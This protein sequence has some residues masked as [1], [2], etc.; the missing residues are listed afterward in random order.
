M[1]PYITADALGDEFD[2]E[3]GK[4]DESPSVSEDQ[5]IA[6]LSGL[7]KRRMKAA[8]GN[9]PLQVCIDLDSHVNFCA[10]WTY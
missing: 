3:E 7:D 1:Y 4:G 5:G 6:G 8:A 10:H 2:S 9:H